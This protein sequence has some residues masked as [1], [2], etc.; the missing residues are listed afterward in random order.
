[1]SLIFSLCCMVM[2]V[3]D[4]KITQ[5]W[6][7]VTTALAIPYAIIVPLNNYVMVK[8]GFYRISDDV[9]GMLLGGIVCV[10]IGSSIAHF[11]YSLQKKTGSKTHRLTNSEEKMMYI[12]WKPMIRYGWII[13][14]ITG[15]R[16]LY[17]TLTRGSSF[18]GSESFA[19]RLTSGI[20]GHFFLTSTPLIPVLFYHWL[21]NRKEKSSIIAALLLMLL[22]FMT[23]VKYHVIGIIITTYLFVSFENRKYL[24]PGAI[25]LGIV[26]AAAFVF[27]YIVSFSLRGVLKNVK[28][29]YYFQ[30]LW[31]YV[32]GSLIYDNYIFDRGLRVG[33]SIFYKLGTFLSSPINLF[34]NSLFGIR[35]FPHQKQLHLYIGINRE[36]GNVVDAIGYLFPSKG[37]TAEV[38]LF[39]LILIIIGCVFT[40]I[41]DY[42]LQKSAIKKKY[43]VVLMYFL[44]Y[45]VVLSFFGTFYINSVPYEI[46]FW[47][48]IFTFIFDK[49][50]SILFGS[51]KIL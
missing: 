9:L 2:I 14:T 12:K 37:T 30:H 36:K 13:I 17:Y 42:S 28:T 41:Y 26:A 33:T 4:N 24:K 43:P 22:F 40:F 3:A 46:L 20:L 18:I 5:R 31:G 39:F 1:M 38:L 11:I 6:I 48:W 25:L 35:L 47:C 15:I 8:Y 16:L 27:N 7:N 49:R 44:T 45:F 10:F 23:F 21:E 51:K 19:G 29:S 50:V 32:S 34:L